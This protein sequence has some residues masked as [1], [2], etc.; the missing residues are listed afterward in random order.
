MLP[1]FGENGHVE[2]LSYPNDVCEKLIITLQKSTSIYP[3][4]KRT[5]GAFD[6]GFLERE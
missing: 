1:G 2:Q 4:S 6:V 5:M 3:E